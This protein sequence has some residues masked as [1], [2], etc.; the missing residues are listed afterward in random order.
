MADTGFYVLCGLATFCLLVAIPRWANVISASL[1]VLVRAKEVQNFE[2]M[3]GLSRDRNLLAGLL[4]LPFCC[5]LSWLDVIPLEILQ[6]FSLSVRCLGIILLLALYGFL[7]F[8]MARYFG[9]KSMNTRLLKV[10]NYS[11]YTFFV[12]LCFFLLCGCVIFLPFPFLRAVLSDSVQWAIFLF[13]LLFLIRKTQIL[14]S[15]N[16]LFKTILYLCALE[17]LPGAA[18]LSAAWFL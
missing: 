3:M 17:F 9:P 12:L 11:F 6:P 14:L 7:R 2:N 10:V 5:T 15:F 16:S 18:L 13:Y 8:V 4:F 1:G